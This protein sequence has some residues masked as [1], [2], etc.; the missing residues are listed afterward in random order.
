M[1]G[2][3]Q[4]KKR[5]TS[6]LQKPGKFAK[7][8]EQPTPQPAM[9][10]DSKKKFKF[11]LNLSKFLLKFSLKLSNL[12]LKLSIFSIKFSKFDQTFTNFSQNT[13]INLSDNTVP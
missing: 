12:F 2:R 11:S 1:Q 4:G 6:P 7:I 9:R 5:G 3:R 8:G 10:I 13:V